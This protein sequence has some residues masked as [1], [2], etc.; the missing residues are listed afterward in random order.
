MMARGSYFSFFFFFWANR[1]FSPG[2]TVPGK[3]VPGETRLLSDI[4]LF[5]MVQVRELRMVDFLL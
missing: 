2:E 4:P 5:V 3:R 1:L